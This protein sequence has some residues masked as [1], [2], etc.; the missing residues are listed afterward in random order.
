MYS[1]FFLYCNF[2]YYLSEVQKFDC[3]VFGTG[4]NDKFMNKSRGW[5]ERHQFYYGGNYYEEIVSSVIN[6]YCMLYV[7]GMWQNSNF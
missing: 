2:A 4:K 6:D 7:M 3:P 5:W 1:H